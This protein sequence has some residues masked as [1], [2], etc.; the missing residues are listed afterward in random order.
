MLCL[1]ARTRRV[2]CNHQ[3]A[4]SNAGAL[5]VT[6][7][8]PPTRG[9]MF[10]RKD[11]KHT[12]YFLLCVV[13]FCVPRYTRSRYSHS[14]VTTRALAL[15]CQ[16][17][18]ELGLAPTRKRG[19]TRRQLGLVQATLKAKGGLLGHPGASFTLGLLVRGRH[20]PPF[21]LNM[22]RAQQAPPLLPPFFSSLQLPYPRA[23]QS[24]GRIGRCRVN[25]TGGGHQVWLATDP[26]PVMLLRSSS[27]PPWAWPDIGL[28]SP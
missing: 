12:Q 3:T 14:P 7:P 23:R 8:T 19:S 15:K 5:S 10:A 16:R 21:G 1:L 24:E 25:C 11:L 9:L 28:D 27:K 22:T 4:T 17:Q 26:A 6:T 20:P 2:R 13:S 18:A